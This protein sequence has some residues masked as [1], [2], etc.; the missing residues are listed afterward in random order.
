MAHHRLERLV[1]ITEAAEDRAK[2]AAAIE[3]RE[4]QRAERAID[5]ARTSLRSVAG[6]PP[7]LAS[8]LL[9]SGARHVNALESDRD[10][11]LE[12]ATV[13][14]TEWSAARQRHRSIERLVERDAER[15]RA[16]R[17]RHEQ[18]ELLD[19]VTSRGVVAD[20]PSTGITTP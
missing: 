5:R 14:N 19:L 8:H 1:R 17:A 9:A 7:A 12:R 18:H 11:A 6:L 13:R 15:A 2:A 10:D 20:T 16:E 3:N 4:V